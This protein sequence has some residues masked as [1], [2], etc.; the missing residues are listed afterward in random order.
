[1]IITAAVVMLIMAC[2]L[3]MFWSNKFVKI[4]S[5]Y[6]ITISVNILVGIVYLS[7]TLQPSYMVNMEYRIYQY[8]NMVK[9]P[10]STIIRA[11]N[12]SISLYMMTSVLFV[13]Q[14]YHIKWYKCLLLLVPCIY[15][16][17]YADPEVSRR[18]SVLLERGTESSVAFWSGFV[19][20]NNVVNRGMLIAYMIMPILLMAFKLRKT[21]IFV[22]RKDMI[23][24]GFCVLIINLYVYFFLIGGMFKSIMFYNVNM[25]G[26][27]NIT[28]YPSGLLTSIVLWLIVML[29]LVVVLFFRPYWVHERT[30]KFLFLLRWNHINRNLSM[31]LHS[32]KNAFFGVSQQCRIAAN[33]IK[34]GE[35]DKALERVQ[36][37]QSIANDY[38]ETVSKIIDLIGTVN[39]K[40]TKVDLLGC[41]KRAVDKVGVAPEDSI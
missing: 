7:K 28:D 11:F 30:N 39:V 20:V 16:F 21:V 37:G 13:K 32:Y 26:L 15:I 33:N 27:P 18:L 8:M 31:S 2:I 24:S 22:N 35:Y 23:A 34:K 38:I 41:I 6:F 4:V 1:M 5:I 14:L 36:L 10:L 25:V 29:V 40:Y 12:C 9:Q 17:I 3:L 19:R